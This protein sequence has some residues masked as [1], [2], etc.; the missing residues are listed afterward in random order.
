VKALSIHEPW[1]SLIAFGIKQYETRTWHRDYRGDLAIHATV[2]RRWIDHAGLFFP[3]HTDITYSPGCIV[4]VADLVAIHR[5]DDLVR[6]A[7]F[8]VNQIVYGDF[9]PGRSIWELRNVRR[10]TPIPARGNMG[11]WDLPAVVE[12]LLRAQNVETRAE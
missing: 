11:L 8:D 10:I 9:S 12:D 5:S 4:A 7:G 1:A 2:N 6:D 3:Q